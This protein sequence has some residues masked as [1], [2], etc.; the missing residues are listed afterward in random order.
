[1]FRVELADPG[2]NPCVMHMLAVTKAAAIADRIQHIPMDFW[3][4]LG[5][6]VLAIIVTIVVLRKLAHMDK[7]ILT[8]VAGVAVSILGFTWIYERN[9]PT[10]ASPVVNVL[11]EFFPTKGRIEH[12]R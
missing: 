1:M 5:L 10:W 3:L 12:K 6:G 9:E 4:R 8:I 7:T 11:S 2:S